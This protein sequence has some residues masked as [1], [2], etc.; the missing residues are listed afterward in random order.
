MEAFRAGVQSACP[1]VDEGLRAA[2]A[3]EGSSWYV[4]TGAVTAP[5]MPNGVRVVAWIAFF[6][7]A[8]LAIAGFVRGLEGCMLATWRICAGHR[9]VLEE[10]ERRVTDVKRTSE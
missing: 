1:V 2:A 8:A 10:A 4:V 7:N 6:L 9:G 3:L 5:W